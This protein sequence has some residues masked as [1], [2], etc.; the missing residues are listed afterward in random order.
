[1]EEDGR[2]VDGP[3]VE[4]AEAGRAVEEAADGQAV[5]VDGRAVVAD[6][7]AVL[8]DGPAAV[9]GNPVGEE[10]A[11]DGTVDGSPAR[12]GPLEVAAVSCSPYTIFSFHDVSLVLSLSHFSH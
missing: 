4:E 10:V 8:V 1:M 9:D 5:V 6:G 3:A 11:G 7:P 12:D 2:V